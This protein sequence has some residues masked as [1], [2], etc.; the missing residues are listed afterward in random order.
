L[1][2]ISGIESVHEIKRRLIAAL[3]PFIGKKGNILSI[4]ALR[5]AAVAALD[6]ITVTPTNPDGLITAARNAD[7][8]ELPAYENLRV[9]YDGQVV[10]GVVANI[11]LVG[12]I[13]LITISAMAIPAPITI[14]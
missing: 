10:A 1:R 6:A 2:R 14:V 12:E 11:R 8:S 3:R 13:E 5:G 7:G 4:A 9:S